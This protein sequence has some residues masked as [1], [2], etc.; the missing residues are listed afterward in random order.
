MNKSSLSCVVRATCK[1]WR[2][3]ALASPIKVDV[4]LTTPYELGS[5]AA[6]LLSPALPCQATG[7]LQLPAFR[8]QS[9][10]AGQLPLLALSAILDVLTEQKVPLEIQRH[11]ISKI[12]DPDVLETVSYYMT[13]N[14][15][16]DSPQLSDMLAAWLQRHHPIQSTMLSSAQ[17]IDMELVKL[18]SKSGNPFWRQHSCLQGPLLLYLLLSACQESPAIAFINAA[19]QSLHQQ[20]NAVLALQSKP[21]KRLQLTH[22]GS[23]FASQQI[24]CFKLFAWTTCAFQYIPTPL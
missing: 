9:P 2:L 22:N 18:L 14:V 16:S 4:T 1:T 24:D 19:M 7:A 12:L 3:K 10:F 8:L 6:W 11:V 5:L 17:Y 20:M 13:H 23:P 15:P 21:F